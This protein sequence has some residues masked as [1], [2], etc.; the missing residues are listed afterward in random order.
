MQSPGICGVV[1]EGAKGDTSIGSTSLCIFR[2][3]V[4]TQ[5]A[6][7]E[8][9]TVHVSAWG[10]R[11]RASRQASRWGPRAD[12]PQSFGYPYVRATG[13]PCISP[14]AC[15]ITIATMWRRTCGEMRLVISD[16]HW[17]ATTVTCLRRIYSKPARV[18][19]CSSALTKS[20]GA[21]GWPRIVRH[22]RSSAAVYFQSGKSRSRCPLP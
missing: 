1:E 16:G 11:P 4:A 9:A 3:C 8:R 18:I 13:R 19:G 10:R 20:L 7:S 21:C 22:A 17:A 2:Y 6:Y 15:M 12:R 5:S 14:V